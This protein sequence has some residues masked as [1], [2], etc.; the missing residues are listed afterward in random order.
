MIDI[1][2]L[3]EG[4]ENPPDVCVKG[5]MT[6]E[7]KV[8]MEAVAFDDDETVS[9]ELLGGATHFVQ[10]VEIDVRV[11]VEMVVVISCIELL[12]EMTV[13]VTGQVVNVV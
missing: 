11:M 1:S 9:G 13:L 2:G 10:I 8:G 3:L 4:K 5:Y 7:A 6:D 12:P